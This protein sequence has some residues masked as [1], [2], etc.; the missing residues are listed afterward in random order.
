M[1]YATVVATTCIKV[2]ER[3][4]LHARA[5]ALVSAFESGLAMPEAFDALAADLARFQAFHCEGYGRL[6]AARGVDAASIA[7]ASDAPAVPTDAFKAARV[8]TFPPEETRFVFRT[9]G[10]TVGARGTHEMRT[11]ATYDMGALAFGRRALT[12]DLP[13]RPV[14]LVLGPSPEEA[15]DSSLTHMI[16]LF[17]RDLGA[18]ATAKDTYFVQ[19]GVIDVTALDQ[20]VARLLASGGPPV[21]LLATS[22]A[23]VHFLDGLGDA[24]FSLPAGS[25]VMQTGGFK[26]KSREVD[27]AELT[28]EVARVFGVRE[29]HVVG[30]YGMTELSSQFYEMTIAGGAR[31]VYAEPP[32]ARVVPV[33]PETLAPVAQGEVGIARV[34]DL[35]NVES[36]FAVQTADRA[37]RVPGGFELLG[38][39]PGAAPRGCSIAL[40]EMLSR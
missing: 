11:T 14:V 25:R 1:H 40:D 4:A 22:F 6:C 33:D 16:D 18:A 26:G 30:E 23:L 28:R 7:K 20:R 34:E 37:R 5:R 31:G 15:K 36:A 21:L 3:D 13:A 8:A 39:A 19:G 2:S 38:R 9:S 32:W 10:T 17:A 12:G 27:A 35:L 29:S 24:T